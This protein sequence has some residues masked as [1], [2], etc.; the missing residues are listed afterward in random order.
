[1]ASRPIKSQDRTGSRTPAANQRSKRRA[2]PSLRWGDRCG[3]KEA[4]GGDLFAVEPSHP[5]PL[6]HCASVAPPH[7]EPRQ[8]LAG[9]GLRP[10]RSNECERHR[11]GRAMS[12]S[13][14]PSRGTAGSS[15]SRGS[16]REGAARREEKGGRPSEGKRGRLSWAAGKRRL[17]KNDRESRVPFAALA[18]RASLLLI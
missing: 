6:G 9:G 12:A 1:M 3:A 16:E 10:V 4:V 7:F 11:A 2:Y 15:G 14:A 13:W 18:L 8:R 5:A 17:R